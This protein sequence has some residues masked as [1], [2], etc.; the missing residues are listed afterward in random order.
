[1]KSEKIAKTA[2]ATQKVSEEKD[3][4]MSERILSVRIETRSQNVRKDLEDFIAAVGGMQIKDMSDPGGYDLII[5]DV[6]EEH[7]KD[8]QFVA[9]ILAAG[10]AGEV[11]LTS[12]KTSPEIL[13]E[14]LRI[15]AKEFFPQPLNGEDVRNALIK[16]KARAQRDRAKVIA[17]PA[18]R[19]KI[20]DVL[21]SKGGVGTTTT[22]VNLATSLAS[23]EGVQSV[24]L[25]D[26]NLLFGDIP[27]FLGIEPM[28]DWMEVAK[29][30]SRLDATYLMSTLYK[31]HSGIYVLPSPSKL[32][33]EY[34]VTPQVIESLLKL[35][36]TLFDYVVIDSGQSFDDISKVIM[37]MSD[38]VLLVTLL[39]LPC[40]IN[41]KRLQDTFRTL[42]YPHDANVE[43]VVN[44][45]HKN[46]TVS[47]AEAEKN[48]DKKFLW[49]IPNDYQTTMSAINQGK[50]LI[51]LKTESPI[52]KNFLDFA[53]SLSGKA[54]AKRDGF[55][56]FKYLKDK[57]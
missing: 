12:L 29:N 1:M 52:T 17:A 19:G 41:V 28:F 42:G 57:S 35:M 5:V 26:M 3:T 4:T 31:H 32:T 48:L 14:A 34:K 44:R 10:V 49:T 33:D 11:F 53:S 56:W 50:P 45:F 39:S 9:N 2:A 8:L 7:G 27:L 25:M 46:S 40:L 15:G 24:A 21:G 47:M 43:I 20:I 13:I 6:G 30:I 22:A 54:Q 23:M 18:K 16:F 51:A 36:H 37:R 38:K 55:S